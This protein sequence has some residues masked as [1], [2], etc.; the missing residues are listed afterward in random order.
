[1]KTANRP[2][3]ERVDL[4]PDVLSEELSENVFALDLGAFSPKRA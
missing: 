2:W 1:M 3:L 4:H